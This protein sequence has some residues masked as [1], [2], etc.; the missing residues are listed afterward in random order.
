MSRRVTLIVL[1]LMTLAACGNG[2]AELSG[3]IRMTGGIAAID[4]TW[5]L[6]SDG[7]VTTPDGSTGV[8]SEENVARLRGLIESSHF[9]D[10]AADQMPEDTCCD[11]FTYE[12]TFKEG[13]TTHTVNTMDASDAPPPLS[14]LV[15]LFRELVDTTAGS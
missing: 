8:M 4:A 5:S 13:K 9:F 12:I 6:D 10:L 11:R 3:S 7:T 1:A 2:P 14:E 15:D